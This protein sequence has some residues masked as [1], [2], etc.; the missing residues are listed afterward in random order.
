MRFRWFA[1]IAVVVLVGLTPAYAEKEKKTGWSSTAELGFVMTNGNSDTQTLN[2]KNESTRSWEKSSF[3]IK[4]GAIRA[5]TTTTTR[6]AIDSGSGPF[7]SETES[8]ATNA[9]AYYFEGRF[10]RKIHDEFFWFAG[11]GWDRNRPAGIDNRTTGFGGVGNIWREDDKITF[12]TDYA[13]SYTDQED[14]VP[15]ATSVGDYVGVR[16]SWD[17]KHKFTESTEYSNG[18]V[19][20]Y[21]LNESDN[22]RADM[23]NAVA[24]AISSKL[25]L[26][27]SLQSRYNNLPPVE[28]LTVVDGMGVPVPLAVPVEFELD[29]LDTIVSISLVVNF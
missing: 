21:G 18:F 22:W 5:E 27:A 2:L 8:T 7:V 25:A 24:V 12:R 14:V 16:A 17:Y 6:I 4:V 11:A 9:E 29:K 13:L 28:L 3:R 20:D 26:K 10:D 19:V 15:S 1:A 23:I